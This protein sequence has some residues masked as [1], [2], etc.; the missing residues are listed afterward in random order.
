MLDIDAFPPGPSFD[1][2]TTHAMGLAFDHARKAVGL[3]DKM[4]GAT[5]LLADRIIDAAAA[6]ERDPDR[7]C[8]AAVNYFNN[9]G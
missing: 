3:S 5:R 9:G 8:A 4:D 7:L 1:P 6:G 2:E